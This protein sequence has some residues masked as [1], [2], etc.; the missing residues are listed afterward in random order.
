M[1]TTDIHSETQSVMSEKPH[2]D[3]DGK[4]IPGERKLQMIYGCGHIL[5]DL[6]AAS[7]F[8]YMIVFFE[9][10]ACLGH[11]EA[12]ALVLIGQVVDAITTPIVGIGCDLSASKATDEPGAGVYKRLPWHLGGSIL[13]VLSFPYLFIEDTQYTFGHSQTEVFTW[14]AI[15]VSLFQIGWATT[16]IS[17]LAM[18]PDLSAGC[19]VRRSSLNA[20]R[21]AATVLSTVA[22]YCVAWGLLSSN[23][24]DGS[25]DPTPTD[26][27]G[28]NSELTRANHIEFR[29]LATAIV[30]TG[31]LLSLVIFH[32][33]MRSTLRRCEHLRLDELTSPKV[34]SNSSNTAKTWLTNYKFYCV[35]SMYMCTRL[36]VNI[37]QSY[38][39]LYLLD[40]LHM[41]RTAIATAPLV[42]YASSLIGT[43]VTTKIHKT[44]GVTPTYGVAI[45][46]CI[47]AS[48]GLYMVSEDQSW[49]VY[50][51]VSVFGF[52]SALLMI[53]CLSCVAGLIGELPGS[54][55]VYGIFSFTDKLSSGAAIMIIQSVSLEN[56]LIVGAFPL[57]VSVVAVVA[58]LLMRVCRKPTAEDFFAYSKAETAESDDDDDI[59]HGISDSDDDCPRNTHVDI[60]GP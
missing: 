54:A 31:T 60:N 29:I 38:L 58:V 56:R 25:A 28:P 35:A 32:G 22:V 41:A 12:G 47:A 17:H 46:G 6:C 8:S 27:S 52:F 49:M 50:P 16:Q 51:C 43:L 15:F 3:S 48:G 1:P 26:S 23:M 2:L 40:T 20:T 21:Y 7:W 55:F 34:K 36:I 10:V 13:V 33:G 4:A 59:V 57:A 44:I 5:N 9:R 45:V 24:G 37:T 30:I 18:I 19:S 14:Y 42:L 39:A 53:S 11:V